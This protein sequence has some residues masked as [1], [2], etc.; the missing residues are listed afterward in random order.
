MKPELTE[1]NN[2]SRVK[3]SNW[4]TRRQ[5][6]YDA[7]VPHE[8]GDIPTSGKKTVVIQRCLH[9]PKAWPNVTHAIYDVVTE[10]E[11]NARFSQTLT[12]WIPPGSGPFPTLLYGDNCWS[13]FNE[14]ILKEVLQRGYIAALFDRTEAAADNKSDY[15][16]TG[17]YKLLSCTEFGTISAWA[18]AYHR[19]V[20]ALIQLPQVR[21]DAIAISGHSRGGKT[22]L[23]A[24]ATDDRIAIINANGSGTGGAAPN[25][26]KT[27]EAETIDSFFESG[28][29]FWFSD[30][31][32]DYRWQ[33]HKLPYDQHFLYG[34]VAPRPLLLTEARQDTAANPPGTYFACQTA[35]ELYRMFQSEK[36]LGWSLREGEHAHTLE[37]FISLL[38]FM[39]WHLLGEKTSIDFQP[40]LFESLS[41]ILKTSAKP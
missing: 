29:I 14:E 15:R 17:I 38:N 35:L 34:L 20:D 2:G 22:T 16:E 30:P 25:H 32:K 3:L 13:F 37:D 1:L 40:K 9:M 24:G 18:W 36:S 21:S 11:N 23:L 7:I 10:F 8:Y 4:P 19:C 6:L 33:D 28:N 27:H 41:K 26:W 31:F 5:E 39:D 12:L